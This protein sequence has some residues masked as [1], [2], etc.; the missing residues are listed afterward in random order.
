M[1]IIQRTVT[2]QKEANDATDKDVNRRFT[3]EVY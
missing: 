3:K 2:P 1:Q